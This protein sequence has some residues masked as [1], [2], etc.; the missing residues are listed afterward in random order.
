MVGTSKTRLWLAAGLAACAALAA[1][2][3]R[4]GVFV[5]TKTADTADGACDRDCSLREAV[6]AANAAPGEDVIVLAPGTY[7]LTRA[8]G[9]GDDA[10]GGDLDF[11]GSAVLYGPSAA[12]TAIDAG[13]IDRVLDV[14]A[15]AALEVTGVTLRN[16]RAGEGGGGAVR[17]KGA[18]SL[19]RVVV[20]S[21]KAIG[22]GALGGGVWS[23]GS[24]STLA[25]RESTIHGNAADGMGGGV[26]ASEA[27]ELVNSTVSGN[28]A[29][30]SGGGVFVDRD[31]DAV[32]RQATISGN[33]AGRGGGIL[34]LS[35]PFISV[36]RAHVGRSIVAGNTAQTDR[37][38]AGAVVS[39]GGNLL[40]DGGF[41]ID[42]GPAKHD[43]EGSAMAPLDP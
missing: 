38:C 13:A 17:N 37:D 1:S 43:L 21:S 28:N 14:G 7:T 30:D 26:A 20:A 16:G 18:L 41:C 4:G 32:I 24:G 31:T 11:T 27:L 15:G 42:F 25:I 40:G 23:A 35:D 39:D 36:E 6:I 19:N 29:G 10:A 2:E 5:T 34:G 12:T 3:A 33:N 8:A 9:G 22:A